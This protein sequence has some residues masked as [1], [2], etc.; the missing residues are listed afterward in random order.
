M[1]CE[2]LSRE[3]Q[4]KTAVVDIDG[5]I[6]TGTKEEVYSEEAG[7]A[8]DKC[9]VIPEGVTLLHKLRGEGIRIVLHTA[10]FLEDEVKTLW[11]LEHNRIPFDRLVM[12]K[13][14]GDIYVDDKALAYR[15]ECT[16]VQDVLSELDRLRKREL[17]LEGYL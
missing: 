16:S 1:G 12:G 17:E 9:R 10:R 11:W 5:V 15:P 7:W 4:P 6:A 2:D 14:Q 3:D 13:P 8:Y